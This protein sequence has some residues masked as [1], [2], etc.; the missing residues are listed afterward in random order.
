MYGA[1]RDLFVAELLF[2][3]TDRK[4]PAVGVLQLLADPGARSWWAGPS[5]AGFFGRIADRMGRSRALNL[6]I[7]MYAMFTGVSFFAQTWWQLDDFPFPGGPLGIG[8]E[9]AVGRV[10]DIG[11]VAAHH[12]RPGLAA[13]RC[14]EP[15]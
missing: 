15:G 13:V 4:D 5:A 1:G 3:V 11:N 9:W 8:G 14:T 2:G 6:T 12:W 7:L 10:S